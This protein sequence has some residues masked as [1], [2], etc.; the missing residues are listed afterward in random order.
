MP[1]DNKQCKAYKGLAIRYSG[2]T[3]D[4]TPDDQNVDNV[5]I[6]GWKDKPAIEQD[7][8]PDYMG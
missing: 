4:R 3:D 1:Y 8:Y 7:Y 2:I 6:Y 5:K